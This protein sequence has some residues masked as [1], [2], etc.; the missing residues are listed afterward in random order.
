MV[1]LF[2]ECGTKTKQPHYIKWHGITSHRRN[3]LMNNM[4]YS[5]GNNGTIWS[6][7]QGG[8]SSIKS[9]I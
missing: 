2:T 7:N 4:T 9:L 6:Q 5:F 8:H 3:E 1:Q